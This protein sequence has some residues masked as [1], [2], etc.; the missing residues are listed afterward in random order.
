MSLK[1]TYSNSGKAARPPMLTQSDEKKKR[2]WNTEKIMS[3]SAIMISLMSLIALFY[4]TNLMREEQELQRNAQLKSTMPYL[5]I[6]NA[7][8]GGP[9]FSIVL[10]NKGIGP[11]IVDST[12]VIYKDSAYQMDLPTFLYQEIPELSKISEIYHSNIAP[13]QLISPNERIE[14]FKVDNSQESANQFLQLLMAI[15]IDYRLIYRSVYD[16]RWALTGESYFPVKLEE[17]E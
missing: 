15:D 4:Q 7:N 12:I 14:I 6:A 17:E 10:S 1:K 2:F 8:Y 13:G 16:E 11:A 9:N 5:M 3:T